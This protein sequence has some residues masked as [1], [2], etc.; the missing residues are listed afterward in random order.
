MN[1]TLQSF[2]FALLAY[3]VV[4]L[5]K[6]RNLPLALATGAVWGCAVLTRG[7][8]L[9]FGFVL[10]VLM[11]R[12]R[13][14]KRGL[15]VAAACLVVQTPFIVL[16]SAHLGRPCGPSTAAD[17]VLALGNTPEAPPGGRD[18]GL[19]AGPMEYPETYADFMARAAARSVPLQMLDFLRREPAAFL[20]LQFRKILLFWES[21]EIPNNVSMY[22]E[23]R[24]ST[25]LACDLPGR[26]GVLLVCVLAGMIAF[27]PVLNVGGLVEILV[28]PVCSLRFHER[29]E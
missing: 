14:W 27:L 6:K 11:I 28:F 7:N 16:N 25:V 2:W 5:L 24:Q 26:S 29:Y 19:P 22:G 3:L 21:G 9:L 1:E 13:A 12:R 4:K 8:A 23:G 18:P 15:A 20:E 10:A 17:A